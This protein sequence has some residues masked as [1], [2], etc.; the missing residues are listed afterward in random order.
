MH[1]ARCRKLGSQIRI[2]LPPVQSNRFR[3][4]HRAHQQANANCQQLNI[5]QRNPDVPSDH[6]AFVKDSIQDIQQIR[7]SGN[8]W[9]SLHDYFGKRHRRDRLGWRLR[10]IHA[11]HPN[12]PQHAMSTLLR[13]QSP[14]DLPIRPPAAL[15]REPIRCEK[16]LPGLAAHFQ[17]L[18]STSAAMGSAFTRDRRT[19]PRSLIQQIPQRT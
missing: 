5:R 16:L 15:T 19:S 2:V 17:Q 7:C 6:Q 9:D 10:A 1:A 3:F 12:Q 11:T 8:R 14:P 18:S 4:I 13:L